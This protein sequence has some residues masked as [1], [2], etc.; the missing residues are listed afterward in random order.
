MSAEYKRV[1]PVERAGGLDNIWR[2][3]LQDPC[4]ILASHVREGMT[5]LDVGCG[6]GFFTIPMAQLVGGTGR[7]IAADLQDGMLEK[8][9]RKVTGTEFMCRTRLLSALSRALGRQV[10]QLFVDR[11]CI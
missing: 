4:R 1:C 8:V 11:R 5:V 9:R 3:W 6:P 10:S 7:V 2:R